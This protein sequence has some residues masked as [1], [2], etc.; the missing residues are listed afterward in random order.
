[1]AF[2][3]D[4]FSNALPSILFFLF[5]RSN[6]KIHICPTIMDRKNI[7]SYKY[8]SEENRF[9]IQGQVCITYYFI[10]S[11]FQSRTEN[12]NKNDKLFN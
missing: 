2:Y 4:R 1:M 12:T 5:T 3:K 10:A 8:F 9:W 11:F 7:K 6:I